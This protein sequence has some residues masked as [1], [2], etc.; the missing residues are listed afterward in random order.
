[1]VALRVQGSGGALGTECNVSSHLAFL[2]CPALVPPSV[3]GSA[4]S[5]REIVLARSLSLADC[6]DLC[7]LWVCAGICSFRELLRAKLS[8]V[9]TEGYK[10]QW[11]V[12]AKS[13]RRRWWDGFPA[14]KLVW[15]MCTMQSRGPVLLKRLCSFKICSLGAMSWSPSQPTHR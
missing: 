13:G 9:N 11:G 14:A 8:L 2:T 6:G 12:G 10:W 1:M 7:P 3:G 15:H 4:S 5:C